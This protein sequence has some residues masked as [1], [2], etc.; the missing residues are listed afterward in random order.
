VCIAPTVVLARSG[1]RV[2]SLARHDQV[3]IDP[4]AGEPAPAALARKELKHLLGLLAA[5]LACKK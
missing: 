1:A 3:T 4:K 5:R 2:T